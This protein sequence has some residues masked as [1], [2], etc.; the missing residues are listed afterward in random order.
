MD[1]ALPFL[2]LSSLLAAVPQAAGSAD[3]YAQIRLPTVDWA[4]GEAG[5]VRVGI[6]SDGAIL[7]EEER[8]GYPESGASRLGGTFED[9][10]SASNARSMATSNSAV[11]WSTRSSNSLFR[12]RSSYSALT[13]SVMSVM[14]PT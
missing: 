6:L 2:V 13:R 14:V 10:R 4:A 3:P 1:S 7:L 12:R 11:R 8:V 5:G 9:A